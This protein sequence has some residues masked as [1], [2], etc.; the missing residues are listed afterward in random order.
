MERR[1][2]RYRS[3]RLATQKRPAGAIRTHCKGRRAGG[4]LVVSKKRKSPLQ[5]RAVSILTPYQGLGMGAVKIGVT[6]CPDYIIRQTLEQDHSG[7]SLS[8][9]W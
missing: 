2:K 6:A 7:P 3:G 8:R 5:E 9:M 4:I 1:R